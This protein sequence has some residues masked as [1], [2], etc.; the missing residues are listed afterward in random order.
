M[1]LANTNSVSSSKLSVKGFKATPCSLTTVEIKL[2]STSEG[3]IHPCKW[4]FF[5]RISLNISVTKQET[6]RVCVCVCVT[7]LLAVCFF[8][9]Q[10]LCRLPLEVLLLH[11]YWTLV[12][13]PS[14]VLVG[15]GGD[16]R[17]AA[18]SEY[19]FIQ[20]PIWFIYLFYSNDPWLC[21]WCC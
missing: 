2:K 13:E 9:A 6:R 8:A 19:F 21:T 18:L 1:Q 11:R 5:G 20:F 3:F 14:I 4:L 7:L 16:T 12:I 10:A 17:A 15:G